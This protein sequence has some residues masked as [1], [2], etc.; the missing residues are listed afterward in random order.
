MS[1]TEAATGWRVEIFDDGQGPSPEAL[2]RFGKRQ[3][4]PK[5]L[6]VFKPE[7]SIGLG[8]AIMAAVA[9]LHGGTITL[10]TSPKPWGA[11]VVF[12][13]P[14]SAAIATRQAA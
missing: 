2:E 7:T 1:L 14:H 3:I 6:E 10:S 9:E 4:N 8:S 13:L 11:V 5:G 12:F